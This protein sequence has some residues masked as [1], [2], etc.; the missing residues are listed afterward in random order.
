MRSSPGLSTL[1]T[2]P[3]FLPHTQSATTLQQKITQFF[4]V[5]SHPTSTSL[6]SSTPVLA[7]SHCPINRSSHSHP[8]PSRRSIKSIL[9]Y[10]PR[11]TTKKITYFT[12]PMPCYDLQ[13][14]WG[15]SLDAIDPSKVFRIFLQNPN[16]LSLTSN[17]LVLQQEFLQ[18]KDY[19]AALFS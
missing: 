7:P 13:D 17:H 10:Q 15:H 18:F 5:K 6:S 19:G 3:A 8:L 11:K 2:L 4:Q 9:C 16:G 12:T 14:S 1:P